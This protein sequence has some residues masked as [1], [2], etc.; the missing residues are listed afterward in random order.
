MP[1]KQPAARP[2]PAGGDDADAPLSLKP[3]APRPLAA[4]RPIPLGASAGPA[5]YARD[6]EESA[7]E[8]LKRAVLKFSPPVLFSAVVHML[9]I[10]IMGLWV[11]QVHV[12]KQLELD[13]SYTQD[14]GQQLLDD[15]M[16]VW[17][18]KP[19]KTDQPVVADLQMPQVSDPFAQPKLSVNLGGTF[20]SVTSGAAEGP[21]ISIALAGREHGIKQALLGAYGGNQASEDAVEAGLAWLDRYMQK[22]GSWSLKGPYP[23]GA[24]FE[25]NEAATAMALL[26]FQGNGHSHRSGKYQ[27]NVAA[28]LKFLLRNQDAD[29]CFFHSGQRDERLYTQAQCTIVLCELYA[30]TKDSEIR[31]YTQ[32][33]LNYC[34]KAQDTEGFGGWRYQPANDSD[35]SVTGWMAMALQSARMGGM[36]VPDD[37]LKHLSRYLDQA[38]VDQQKSTYSYLPGQ[39]VPGLAM[40][41]EALL[42]REYL[43]W[44]PDNK[45]LIA[46]ARFIAENPPRWEERDV[47]YWYYAT[48]M[49]HHM[50]GEFWKNWNIA[51]RD[52]LV[53]HQE[54]SG[55]DRGSWNPLGEQPDIWAERGQGGRLYVTCLS[56]FIL[57][58]Y[59]RHLPLYSPLQQQLRES[60]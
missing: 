48:Q 22:D 27:K 52:L 39:G 28:G 50:E 1:P 24:V 31:G 3:P 9:L 19:E 59:Y 53:K 7:D 12:K 45:S 8:E 54:R 38:A 18:D 20:S 47:Y 58:V 41:A 57:E 30:M 56:L 34:L 46:G 5:I 37:A 29:G 23:G 42:C 51:Q 44:R 17:V 13:V 21:A 10:I 4:P 60:K 55:K 40:T 6:E 15:R 26:A 33:A 43:G 35:T 25:N 36:Q 49:M 14:L 32:K 16:H 2:L 11:L